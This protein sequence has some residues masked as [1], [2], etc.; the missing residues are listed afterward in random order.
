MDPYRRVLT[1][2]LIG[3]LA[4]HP[5]GGLYTYGGIVTIRDSTFAENLADGGAAISNDGG[6]VLITNS[7]IVDNMGIWTGTGGI[8]S[9]GVLRMTNTMLA[10]N[11]VV[12]RGFVN[13]SGAL[14]VYGG[15]AL[16]TNCTIVDNT[17]PDGGGPGGIYPNGWRA[18]AVRHH[19]SPQYRDPWRRLLWRAHLSR[20]QPHRRSDRLHPHRTTHGPDG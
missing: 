16:L 18:G 6:T 3:N 2:I 5:G 11:T 12:A 8:D 10:R 4:T 1:M 15:D 13:G 20:P 9:R 17:A 19:S 7:A 14:S